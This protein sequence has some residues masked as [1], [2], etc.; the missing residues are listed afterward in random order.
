MQ[1][2]IDSEGNTFGDGYPGLTEGDG[3]IREGAK[4]GAIMSGN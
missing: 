3:L 1:Q 4:T 2:Q